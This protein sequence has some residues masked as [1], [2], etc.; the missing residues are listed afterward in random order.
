MKKISSHGWRNSS[1]VR[2]FAVFTHFVYE[3]IAEGFLG[4]IFTAYEAVNKKFRESLFGRLIVRLTERGGGK[5]YRA[6][7]RNLALAMD[8]SFLL[9]GILRVLRGLCRCSL[10]TFGLFLITSGAYSGIMFWLF[11]VVWGSTAVGAISLFGGVAAAVVGIPLLFSENSLGYALAKGAFFGKLLT[12][13]FGVSDYELKN[14]EKKGY[15]GYAISIPLGMVVGALCALISPFYLL[16][17]ILALLLLLLVLSVPEAGIMLL[18]VFLPFAGLVPQGDRWIL[19]LSVLPLVGYFGK[20]VRGN[21]IFHLEVQDLP[22]LLMVPMFLISGVSVA[23]EEGIVRALTCALLVCVYF[24]IVNVVATPRWL[25]RC[26]ISLIVAATAASLFG[27]AQFLYAVLTQG[28]S[29]FAMLGPGVRAGFVDHTTFAYFLVLAY[30]FTITAFAS[31]KKRFHRVLT[32][33]AMLAVACATVLTW[34]QSAMI[35]LLVMTVVF[36]LMH[37][38]RVF[39]F[40]LVGSGLLPAVIAVLPDGARRTML[41]ALRETS[42]VAI[43]RSLDAGNFAG[44][45]FFEQ[46]TG[47]FSRSAGLSRLLFG[48]GNGGIEHFCAL[49]TT[50]PAGE[51]AR[52]LNFWLYNLLEGGVVG[53]LLPALFFFL[54]CQNCFSMLRLK[55]E[56]S[57]RYSAISGIVLVC[58][59]L[60]LS[61]FRYSWYDP[62]ALTVFFVATAM[63]G[64]DARYARYR[65]PSEPTVV[66]SATAAEL[67]YFG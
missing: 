37:N 46:G 61:I 24:L 65:C 26:R 43:D 44:R 42:G 16:A 11:S 47:L 51:V 17:G 7:R 39:P 28:W 8:R 36:L 30:P 3:V 6:V 52:S 27:G 10:R 56:K 29:S 14:V 55:V 40:V 19:F 9:N 67:D 62:A 38:R 59:V 22:V 31:V 25:H 60:I 48:L 45:V 15:R 63:I 33:L 1:I 20:L 53:V 21:R 64:A 54:L 50:L 4:R 41:N 34:V 12:G 35:A 57:H 13:M 58:G 5:Y 2:W 23:G 18:T 66:N 49:Y 32:G